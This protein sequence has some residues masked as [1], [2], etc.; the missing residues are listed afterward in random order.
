MSGLR[1][2]MGRA[3]RP[4]SAS[5]ASGCEGAVPPLRAASRDIGPVGRLREM[6]EKDDTA[7][8]PPRG[9]SMWDWLSGL[10]K[11]F[12]GFGATHC[13]SPRLSGRGEAKRYQ[14]WD[15]HDGGW[16]RRVIRWL[17]C[18]ARHQVCRR[19]G[20]AQALELIAKASRDGGAGRRGGR[21]AVAATSSI[22]AARGRRRGRSAQEVVDDPLLLRQRHLEADALGVG[23]Q[24]GLHL[25]LELPQALLGPY[26]V[27]DAPGP[28]LDVE[29]LGEDGGQRLEHDAGAAGAGDG[30][31]C[32]HGG[33]GG[34]H[35]VDAT[36][37]VVLVVGVPG[38]EEGRL[39]GPRD[40]PCGSV[41][42]GGARGRAGWRG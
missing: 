24:L 6:A 3:N 18:W 29:V 10:V 8:S 40:L 26:R 39:A 20:Q 2:L 25:E 7:M 38:G 31:G 36:P 23:P 34:Q 5:C 15:G 16:M 13:I 1:G 28:G 33:V 37:G 30:H 35:E 41:D 9:D 14:E 4:S 21:G 11:V 42:D 12:A 22:T 19:R 32:W 27:Q 17:T